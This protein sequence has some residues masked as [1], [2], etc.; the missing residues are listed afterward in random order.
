M[1]KHDFL[2]ERQG[3]GRNFWYCVGIIMVAVPLKAQDGNV[4]D[5]LM[6]V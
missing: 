3:G 4:H 5:M 6:V 2:S 1:V